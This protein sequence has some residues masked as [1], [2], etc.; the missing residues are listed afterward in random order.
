MDRRTK[1]AL[2]VAVLA[3]AS[4][5]T[6]AG[7]AP[8][9]TQCRREIFF[10]DGAM[11]ASRARLQDNAVAKPAELCTVWRAH[12]DVLKKSVA[13]YQR[14]A[15]ASERASKLGPAQASLAEFNEAVRQRCKAM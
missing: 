4:H 8:E 3:M 6:P 5:A 9:T 2:M 10:T 7:A 15:D 12:V 11:V 14:C 13:S 1:N